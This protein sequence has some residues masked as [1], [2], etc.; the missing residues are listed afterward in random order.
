[1]ETT[2]K[3]YERLKYLMN[4]IQYTIT[5]DKN[6]LYELRAMIKSD[7]EMEIYIPTDSVLKRHLGSL[8]NVSVDDNR[9]LVTNEGYR[10]YFQRMHNLSK[11]YDCKIPLR[12]LSMVT[13]LMQDTLQVE[14]IDKYARDIVHRIDKPALKVALRETTEYIINH[15][16]YTISSSNLGKTTVIMKMLTEEIILYSEGARHTNIIE[17]VNAMIDEFGERIDIYSLMLIH[18]FYL[19]HDINDID[20]IVHRIQTSLNRLDPDVGYAHVRVDTL[21]RSNL[22]SSVLSDVVMENTAMVK[23]EVLSSQLLSDTYVVLNGGRTST[24]KDMDYITKKDI[25]IPRTGIEIGYIFEHWVHPNA[26]KYL[27]VTPKLNT[28]DRYVIEQTLGS[29]HNLISGKDMNDDDVLFALNTDGLSIVTKDIG[30]ENIETFKTIS[31][32]D[33]DKGKIE[34]GFTNV[35]EMMDGMYSITP[36]AVVLKKSPLETKADEVMDTVT[37]GVRFDPDGTIKFTRSK[38]QNLLDEYMESKRRI[39]LYIKNDQPEKVKDELVTLFAI[40]LYVE[41][42]YMGDQKPMFQVRRKKRDEAMK[43]RMFAINTFNQAYKYVREHD[44]DF[45]FTK[46]FIENDTDKVQHK[47]T[48]AELIGLRRVVVGL[49]TGEA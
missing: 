42:K 11:E 17:Y 40:I 26:F 37:E 41:S 7:D 12:L 28:I 43:A 35:N 46:Y 5:P 24:I 1:M 48:Y 6:I 38:Q 47:F 30:Q 34:N 33:F 45:D 29:T 19:L 9:A 10:S 32:V 15:Y 22:F 21:G 4:N 16:N 36:Y 20:A 49:L 2:T 25:T 31:V 13:G 8:P 23:E 3:F 44:D 39:Q 18:A 14:N 27:G